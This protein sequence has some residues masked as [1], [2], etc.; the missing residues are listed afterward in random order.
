MKETNK[1]RE[2]E[3]AVHGSSGEHAKKQ[4][5]AV[6]E[7]KSNPASEDPPGSCDRIPPDV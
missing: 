5:K 2:E 3:E 6:V 4:A 7:A 1:A